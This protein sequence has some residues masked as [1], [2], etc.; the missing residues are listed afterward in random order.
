MKVVSFFSIASLQEK[1][2]IISQNVYYF[3]LT[4]KII[5]TNMVV[6]M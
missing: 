1:Q 5:A 4:Y 2:I 6:V 3:N